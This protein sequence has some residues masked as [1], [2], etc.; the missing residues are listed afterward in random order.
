MDPQTILHLFDQTMRKDAPAGRATVHQRPGLTF[1]TTSAPNPSACW[2]IYTHLDPVDAGK[3]I[4][5]TIDFLKQYNCEIEWVIYDHDMPPDL[6][7]RLL[8]LGFISESSEAVMALDL[9][10]VPPGFWE[11]SK[12]KICKITDP[13]Q[14]NIITH[15]ESEVWGELVDDLEAELSAELQAVPGQ[16]SIYVAYA[17]EEPASGAWVRFYPGRQFAKLYGGT[18]VAHQRSK[19]LYTALVKTRAEEARQRGVRYLIVYASPMSHRV[20]E[21]L[22]FILLTHTQVFVLKTRSG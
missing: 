2:V 6:K 13:E 22:G 16:T 15:I 1:F 12:V 8:T 11:P 10:T 18:T 20:L 21:K 3:A 19:G 9:E 7:E 5:C 17:D 4:Q 14:L